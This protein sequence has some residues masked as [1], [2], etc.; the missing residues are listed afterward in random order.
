LNN[1][2]ITIDGPAGSGKSTAARLLAAKLGYSFLDTGAMY[3]A[4][5]FAVM[6]AGKDFDNTDEIKTIL[7]QSGF[8]FEDAGGKLA[9]TLNGKDIS[10]QIRQPDVTAN[11]S[12]IASLG[13]VRDKLVQMQRGFAAKAVNVVTEGRDQ[14]TVVFPDAAV[15][16]FL[17]AS[18][19][20]RAKRR[21][22]ELKA[23]G[24]EVELKQIAAAIEKRDQSDMQ[25]EIAP[26][27]KAEDALE[28][29]TTG[30]DIDGVVSKLL[31]I[32]SE[33]LGLQS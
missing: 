30:L 21:Y 20:E 1:R 25:R 17:T 12:R 9:A 5:T 3:R 16:F 19:G 18:V 33:K 8:S 4:V 13:F 14:G 11:V 23:K 7:E 27:R 15:K 2:I 24:S 29:D 31:G 28:I 10:V 6:D 22:E 26:L 32:V